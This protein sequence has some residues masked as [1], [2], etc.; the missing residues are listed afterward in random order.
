MITGCFTI[1]EA[2]LTCLHVLSILP[3]YASS[4]PVHS[5]VNKLSLAVCV[6]IAGDQLYF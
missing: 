3:W 6:M 5:P 4:S 1:V 2:K